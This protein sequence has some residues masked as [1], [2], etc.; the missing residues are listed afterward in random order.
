MLNT[1]LKSGFFR[2]LF[3]G[4][5]FLTSLLVAKISGADGFGIISLLILNGALFLLITGFGTD[6]A[7]IWHGSGKEVDEDGV[8]TIAFVTGVFQIAL[9]G[10]LEYISVSIT[11]KSLLTQQM[12][13]WYPLIEFIYCAGLVL[14][15]KYLS[16][17]YARNNAA[18]ANKILLFTSL[19][20]FTFFFFLLLNYVNGVQPLP[21]FCA[22]ILLQGLSL[23]IIFHSRFSKIKFQKLSV[24]QLNS[25]FN[26]SLLV[27]F[28]NLIQFLAYRVDFWILDFYFDKTEVGVYAQACQFAQLLW[29][30]PR[31]FASMVTPAL[32]NEP[33]L[34][35]Y[36]FAQLFRIVS[37]A[38]AFLLVITICLA[39]LLYQY[40]LPIE[41][42]N[43]F[44]ALV[45]MLPGYFLFIAVTIIPPYFSSKRM[46][47]VNFNTTSICFIVI[48]IFDLLLIPIY[49]IKG[50]AFASS[51]VYT[52][53]AIL[54]VFRLMKQTQL[55]MNSLWKIN[56]S[57]LQLLH[58]FHF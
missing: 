53:A 11:G 35:D 50:A 42:T 15:D 55:P 47:W 18:L 3:L 37:L 1:I 6:A 38:S 28:T 40:F 51:I 5:T 45:I 56:K 4:V 8:F 13:K 58:K 49:G 24:D 43:G 9:F 14:T 32:R 27:F 30:V 29:I 25:V 31:I 12:G 22:M 7:V 16:L 26:F 39:F 52:L 17:F 20:S 41:F 34:D 2:L 10:L 19:L 23:S 33:K 36:Q 44:T 54:I 46:L 21:L 48:V 57:D